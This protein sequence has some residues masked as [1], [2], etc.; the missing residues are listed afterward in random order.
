[1]NLYSP[2]LFGLNITSTFIFIVIPVV[3]VLSVFLVKRKFLWTAPII[4]TLLVILFSV[5]IS[6]ITLLTE[7]EY[8]G[9]FLVFIVPIQFV[10]VILLTVILYLVLYVIKR[11]KNK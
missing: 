5:S 3:S 8:R 4:S 11:R 7:E 10:I 9:M 6:G 2:G 1:M